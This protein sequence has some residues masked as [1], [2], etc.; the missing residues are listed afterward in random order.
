MAPHGSSILRIRSLNRTPRQTTIPA[1]TPMITDAAGLT[2]AQGAVI[3]TRPASIPLQAMV[4]SGLPKRR[5]HR[6]IAAAEPATAAR[7]VFTA[8]TEMRRSVAP[9]V[10]PGLKPIRPKSKRNVPVTTNT[11]FEA[12]NARGLPSAPYLPSRG[13]RMSAS[14]IAQKP[15][16]LWTTDEPA[17]STY[18]WPRCMLEPNW[19]SHPPPQT[20]QPEIG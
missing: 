18:P 9:S 11:M 14:A 3:A 1:I 20:Q 13:P 15:P 16:M 12:G 10:D 4:I 5:Y 2:N 17:K 7:L 19:E 6:S 8:T